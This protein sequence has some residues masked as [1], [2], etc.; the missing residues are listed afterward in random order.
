MRLAAI[1]RGDAGAQAQYRA[2]FPMSALGARGHDVVWCGSSGDKI[3]LTCL[4]QCDLVHIQRAC[5]TGTIELLKHL[6]A[7]GVAI[8]W[9]NDD[10]I[11]AL[12]KESPHYRMFGGLTGSRDFTMQA[13][14]M[15]QADVVTTTSRALQQRFHATGAE[16]VEIV[17]NYIPWEFLQGE[18]RPH[19]GLVVGWVAGGEHAVDA[20]QLDLVSGLRHILSRYP[21]VRVVSIGLGLG[22]GH[23]RYEHVKLVPLRK[24][25]GTLR[26]FDIGL[27]PLADIPFNRCRSS[28]KAKEYASAG[29]PWLGSPVGEYACL[30]PRQ[31]GRLV[32]DDGW[33]EAIEDLIRH[34]LK[35]RL[36]GRRARRWARTQTIQQNAREWES[37]FERAINRA[38]ERRAQSTSSGRRRTAGNG[39]GLPPEVRK[40]FGMPT[41]T[42]NT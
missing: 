34:P 12:P 28:I 6:R 26:G 19:P 39:H 35:R 22:L 24:L 42:P 2:I 31:G 7:T 41:E 14:A 23:E 5:E 29:V 4:E 37:I 15:R 40:G 33:R 11:T 27:A 16:N 30:G 32:P 10:D 17:E 9:D 1:Y 20:K 3:P 18:R 13:R 38:R 25:P 36:L 21:H 8:C